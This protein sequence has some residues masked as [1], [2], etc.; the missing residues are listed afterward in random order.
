MEGIG[1]EVEHA[2]DVDQSQVAIAQ[3]TRSIGPTDADIV[4]HPERNVASEIA[5]REYAEESSLE[6]S[7]WNELRDRVVWC[8]SIEVV[9]TPTGH[10]EE[11]V[12]P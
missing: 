10:L 2:S 8:Q 11:G 5:R 6:V 9:A 7:G 3:S 1:R 4:I 12:H